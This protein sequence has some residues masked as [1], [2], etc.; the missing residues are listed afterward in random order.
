MRYSVAENG[1]TLERCSLRDRTFEGIQR[2]ANGQVYLPLATFGMYPTTAGDEAGL[3]LRSGDN[4]NPSA[5]CPDHGRRS[6]RRGL[7]PKQARV[8]LIEGELK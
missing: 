1:Q 3:R 2:M 4:R 7:R 5:T 6:A 8:E